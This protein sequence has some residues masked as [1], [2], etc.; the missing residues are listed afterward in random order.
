MTDEP[1]GRVRPTQRCLTDI[2]VAVPDLG[3]RLSQLDHPVVRKA[4]TLPIEDAAGRAERIRSL[5]DRRWLKVKTSDLRAA[6]G[7][8]AHE[9]PEDVLQFGERWWLVAAG[10]RQ[11]DS[12]QRD[13]YAQIERQAHAGGRNTCS[14]DFLLP[15]SWDVDRLTAEAGVFATKVIQAHV[16]HAAR[17]SLLNSDTRAFRIGDADVR[18]RIRMQS[19]GIVYLAIGTTGMLD[20]A[21]FAVLLTALPGLASEEWAPEPGG[22]LGIEPAGGEIL[23]STILTPELQ[24][25]LMALK[26]EG[27]GM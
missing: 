27:P 6:A 24:T 19:D 26:A 13:F 12:A 23:W 15:T 18:V 22:A 7:D 10:H 2:G 11:Q 3:Y 1:L 9:L 25:R 16:R 5:T 20:I 21:F 17:E 4:Q 8:L 14:T